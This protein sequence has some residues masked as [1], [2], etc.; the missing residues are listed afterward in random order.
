M[1]SEFATKC[2]VAIGRMVT[3]DPSVVALIADEIDRHAASETQRLRE[4]M[5]EAATEIM[6]APVKW[7]CRK[8][9]RPEAGHTDE[10]IVKRLQDAAFKETT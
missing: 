8:F 2:A 5:K 9:S 1:A 10:C 4:L 7:C 3:R 6:H